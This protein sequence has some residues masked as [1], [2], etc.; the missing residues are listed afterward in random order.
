[1]RHNEARGTTTIAQYQERN[2]Q[3]FHMCLSKKILLCNL[4]WRHKGTVHEQ[5]HVMQSFQKPPLSHEVAWRHKSTAHKHRYATQW[6]WSKWLPCELVWRNEST[7][8][9]T[10]TPRYLLPV[11]PVPH[12]P[13]KL[14]KLGPGWGKKAHPRVSQGFSPCKNGSSLIPRG[15]CYCGWHGQGLWQLKVRV[16]V[17]WVVVT[18]VVTVVDRLRLITGHTDVV[19]RSASTYNKRCSTRLVV[20]STVLL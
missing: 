3:K 5:D 20:Q 16:V 11:Q 7:M 14:K 12:S 4:V 18:R 2:K 15:G 19:Q 8:Y 13:Q 17:T 9:K 6:Q 1:M 10:H